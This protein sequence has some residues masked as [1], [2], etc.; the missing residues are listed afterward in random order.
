MKDIFIGIATTIGTMMLLAV[1]GFVADYAHEK[2][3]LLKSK[4]KS[5]AAKQLIDKID[6]IIRLAV[7]M[8]NQTLVDD[9]K[10]EGTFD[11]EAKQQAFLK[12]FTAIDNMLSDADK[13]QIEEAF[14]DFK[15]FI[16]ANIETYIKDSKSE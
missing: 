16:K 12:T 1:L 7:E 3:T 13:E 4:V 10:A 11:D 15:T 14:G 2:L 9:K 8:T 6:N 5:E